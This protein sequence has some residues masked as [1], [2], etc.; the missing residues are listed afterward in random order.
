MSIGAM[1][2]VERFED[3]QQLGPP[4]KRPDAQLTLEERVSNVSR[5]LRA[6]GTLTFISAAATFLLQRWGVANDIERYLSLLGIT[7]LLPAA[8]LVCGLGLKEGKS[9]RTLL[10]AMLTILP[11]HFAVLGGLVYSQFAW[12]MSEAMAPAY[13]LWHGGSA[14]GVLLTVGGSVAALSLLTWFAH[15]TF[16]RSKALP[17]TAAALL[18]N[19]L[20]LV[21]LRTPWVAAL[22]ASVAAL[23]VVGLDTRWLRHHAA[24]RTA[25][26]RWARALLYIPSLL[27]VARA[28]NLY[29]L[30][31]GFFALGSVGVAA[32]SVAW[33]LRDASGARIAAPIAA[34]ALCVAALFETVA[35]SSHLAFW[36][37]VVLAGLGTSIALAGLAYSVP[38][39]RPFSVPLSAVVALT[40]TLVAGWLGESNAA[41]AIGLAVGIAGSTYGYLGQRPIVMLAGLLQVAGAAVV[42]W[43]SAV[44][45]YGIG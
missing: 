30:T 4:K 1:H 45:E 20:M 35:L 16:V 38:R 22:L 18:A 5:V 34:I 7:A 21:P 33:S 28:I 11:V 10:G 17:I 23:A 29:P 3:P 9:A 32:F 2:D 40:S 31:A 25:E 44:S 13:A 26:G 41:C 19:S 42:L 8:G 36:V 37:S 14:L 43:Q 27:I 12:D 39:S 15:A 24:L 6:V